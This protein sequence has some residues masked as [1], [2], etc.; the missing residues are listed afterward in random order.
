MNELRIGQRI[1]VTLYKLETGVPAREARTVVDS[2]TEGFITG[3][4]N[5]QYSLR[6]I[7]ADGHQERDVYLIASAW[8]PSLR[9]HGGPLVEI[10]DQPPEQLGLRMWRGTA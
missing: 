1:R 2:V 7:Y 6:V 9:S 8:G 4:R 5:T 10:L 3:L